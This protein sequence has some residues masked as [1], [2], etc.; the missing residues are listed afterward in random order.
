MQMNQ[1]MWNQVI[2]GTP[3]Q[4]LVISSWGADVAYSARLFTRFFADITGLIIGPNSVLDYDCYL[5]QHQKTSTKIE[6]HPI[7]IGS[8]CVLGQRSMLLHSSNLGDG[9][10]VYPLSAVPPNEH[11]DPDEAVGGVLAV[12]YYTQE[13]EAILMTATKTLR[14]R[15]DDASKPGKET[16]DII[17][18]GAGAGGLVAAYEF[19]NQGLN[20]RILEKTD[21]IMGCWKNCANA[22]SHVAVSEATYRFPGADNEADLGDY[23]PRTQ[24]LKNGHHFFERYNLDRITEFNAEVTAIN[25]FPGIS[26]LVASTKGQK[27][28]VKYSHGH[29]EVTYTRGGKNKTLSCSG[30]FV[31]T[32]AQCE[33]NH[34][35]FPGEDTVFK[36]PTA[37]GSAN[38]IGDIVNNI[39]GKNVVI[40]GGGAFA[41]E[42][43]RTMLMHGAK[44][45]TLVHRSTLQ[46][47]PRSVHYLM[48]TEKDRPF[49]DYAEV[50]E[51]AA[52]WAGFTIGEN[53]SCQLAPLMHPTTK[54]QPTASDVFFAFGKLGLVTLVRGEICEMKKNSAVVNKN[55]GGTTEIKCDVF[56]KCIGWMEPGHMLKKFYPNFT[57][58][59]FVFLNSSPRIMFVCDPH[60]SYGTTMSD[61]EIKDR[62]AAI[63]DTVPIGG[64][65]SVLILARVMAWLHMYNLGNDVTRFN[66]MLT[67]LPPASSHPTCTWDEQ[68][69]SFPSNKE[70]SDMIHFKI[71]THKD[72]VASKHPTVWDFFIMSSAYLKRDIKA[73]ATNTGNTVGEGIEKEFKNALCEAPMLQ[74]IMSTKIDHAEEEVEVVEGY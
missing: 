64:T 8:R 61:S 62:Y 63:L 33:Q 3:W 5:E 36:G 57:H 16:V 69:F 17:I 48:S 71:G 26:K 49:R 45:V 28:V 68:K 54:A 1:Q 38:D 15:T 24:V 50:Y 47:W 58:R 55:V 31:A 39:K 73:Y 11:V 13:P 59:N 51:K 65:F 18:V 56:I 30:V 7:T 32:G 34:H 35:I 46:V 2:N 14:A 4:S 74:D 42:N 72:L 52:N 41:V 19:I 23:P 20:V 10:W 22:T 21:D 40:V 44:H 70:L 29:C 25:D 66:K 53:D 67:T 27:G 60:Y 9:A 37:Y 12:S 43:V 6:F